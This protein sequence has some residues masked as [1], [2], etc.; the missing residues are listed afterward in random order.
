ME[1]RFAATR[2]GIWLYVAIGLVGWVNPGV[3]GS[4]GVY[5]SELYPGLDRVLCGLRLG[6]D[7]EGGLVWVAEGGWG[8]P[9]GVLRDGRGRHPRFSGV[10][11]GEGEAASD[12]A[13]AGEVDDVGEG[14]LGIP[15]APLDGYLVSGVML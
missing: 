13:S 8:P 15:H 2:A 6:C 10:Q 7:F 11:N 5:V 14:A 4:S 9:L 1:E 12:V 3:Y